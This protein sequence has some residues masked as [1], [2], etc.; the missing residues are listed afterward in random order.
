MDTSKLI[1]LEVEGG[2]VKPFQAKGNFAH[3]LF[4]GSGTLSL[5]YSADDSHYDEEQKQFTIPPSGSINIEAD[6]SK[7]SYYKI[8]S[9]GTITEAYIKYE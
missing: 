5:H 4:V 9:T 7:Y 1:K 8:T 3:F 6:L 2:N